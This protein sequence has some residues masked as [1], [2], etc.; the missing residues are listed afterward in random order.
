MATECQLFCF[1]ISFS[2]KYILL[3]VLFCTTLNSQT[4]IVLHEVQKNEIMI[5]YGSATCHYCL[6]TKEYLTKK[7]V[8]FVFYDMDTNPSK[9][10]EMHAKLRKV[11][12]ST[13][14]F[15]I[16][17]VDKGGKIITNDYSSFEVF[18]SKLN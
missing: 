12:I 17:V 1:L 7:N 16:P 2:M 18:L 5:V 13:A 15:Q 4:K 11:N 6:D 9:I 3:I 10:T 8:P 14:D